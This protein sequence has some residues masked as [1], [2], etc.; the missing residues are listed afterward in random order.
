[1]KFSKYFKNVTS[2]LGIHLDYFVKYDFYHQIRKAKD[3][4]LFLFDK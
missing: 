3:L 4:G 1:M 2:A